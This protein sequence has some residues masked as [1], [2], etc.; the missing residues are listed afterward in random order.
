MPSC[1]RERGTYC[2]FDCFDLPFVSATDNNGC[3]MHVA[4]CVS[5]DMTKCLRCVNNPLPQISNRFRAVRHPPCT[6]SRR[7]PV[8]RG[9][10]YARTTPNLSLRTTLLGPHALAVHHSPMM[11]FPK[12]AAFSSFFSCSSSLGIGPSMKH[13]AERDVSH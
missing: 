13:V 1:A 4:R 6:R 12:K 9:R 8:H 5:R 2:V 11:L 7:S 10:C 3:G